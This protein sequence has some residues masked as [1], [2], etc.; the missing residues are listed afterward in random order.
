MKFTKILINILLSFILMI[1]ILLSV[2]LIIISNY[3]S[4]KN[5][6]KKFDEIKMYN[7]VYEEVRD[8][9]ENYI[10]QSGLDINIIDKICTKEKVKN[11]IISVVDEM[12]GEGK[13]EI[14]F[15]VIRSN[16]ENAINEYINNQGRKISKQEEQNIK[17]F[18]D[19]IVDSYKEKIGFYQKGSNKLSDKLPYFL[20]LIE[21]IKVISIGSTLLLVIILV[22][23]NYKKVSIAGSYVGVS[24][25][26]SGIIMVLIKNIIYSKINIHNLIIF[27]K[28]LSETIISISNSILN[29]IGTIGIWCMVIGFIDIIFMNYLLQFTDNELK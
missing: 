4:R 12:Y 6:L 19:L 21:K 7:S 16:L 1:G 25:F 3:T 8:G 17:K 26:S 23:I 14:D 18:E 11:D 29:A 27:T 5:V 24:I 2:I 15:S 20:K 22:V 9:F 10:Y 28:S 13:S